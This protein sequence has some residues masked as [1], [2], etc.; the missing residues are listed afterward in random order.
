DKIKADAEKT[1]RFYLNDHSSFNRGFMPSLKFKYKDNRVRIGR[2]SVDT[3]YGGWDYEIPMI[4]SGSI[5]TLPN[6]KEG[7]FYSGKL[8]E[9]WN[10]YS[11]VTTKNSNSFSVEKWDK[12]GVMTPMT[13]ELI[14]KEPHYALATI[15]DRDSWTYKLGVGF[16]DEVRKEV[17]GNIVK[18][19]KSPNTSGLYIVNLLGYYTRL[20]GETKK[21]A[22]LLKG[23]DAENLHILTGSLSYIEGKFNNWIAIGYV[24]GKIPPNS[25]IDTDMVYTGDQSIDRNHADMYSYQFGSVYSFTNNFAG[26]GYVTLTDGYED[27]T[28]MTKVEG[29]GFN[30]LANYNFKGTTLDGLSVTAL[31][32]KAKEER[33]PKSGGSK[34]LDYYDIKL[35]AQYKFDVNPYFYKNKF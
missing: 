31:I 24:S 23:H 30:L 13:L 16:Q 12:A 29:I 22:H 19:I 25:G 28:K 1:T 3:V 4:S 32:N 9:D 10:I 21:M 17:A 8:A 2:F 35:I 11:M 6:M 20:E 34:S 18:K 27:N 15:Y 33:S 5:R 14:D 26:G 7:I